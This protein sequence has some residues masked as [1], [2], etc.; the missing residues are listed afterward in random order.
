MLIAPAQANDSSAALAAGSLVLTKQLSI[1]MAS[2]DLRISSKKISIR[3]E[4]ANDG[5]KDVETIVAFPLPDIDMG[6]FYESPLG[7]VTDDPVNFVGFKT[8][9]NGKPV[10]VEVEQRAFFKGKDVTDFLT[11]LKVPLNVQGRF[12]QYQALPEATFKKLLATGMIDDPEH[13]GPQWILRTKLYWKQ[14]FPARKTVT[15]DHSYQ[16]VTGSEFFGDFSLKDAEQRKYWTKEF[17]IDQPTAAAIR[18]RLKAA[19]DPNFLLTANKTEYILK[20]AKNWSGPIGKFRLTLDKLK[21]GNIISLCWAGKLKK[22]SP[23]RFEFTAENFVPKT[24]IKLM[25]L[26]IP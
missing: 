1:R 16:P 7:T 17:C 12:Q 22:I 6:H 21:A 25:V 4:F 19:K 2:E 9:A 26:D 23:T 24:D 20:T 18:T 13:K 15:M 11:S 10:K 5:N 3:Y 8:I 14:N